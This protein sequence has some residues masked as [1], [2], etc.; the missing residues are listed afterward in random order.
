[1]RVSQM[2]TL[3]SR[4]R[5]S[6]SGDGISLTENSGW[7]DQG[8]KKTTTGKHGEADAKGG[9]GVRVT[10]RNISPP[11]SDK[12]ERVMGIKAY[13]IHMK[14]DVDVESVVSRD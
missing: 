10:T 12:A 14:K 13:E 3:A 8:K 9:K 6:A 11:T 5:E 7:Y 4:K 2:F 1:M